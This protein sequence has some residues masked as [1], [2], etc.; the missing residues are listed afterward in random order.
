MN[1]LNIIQNYMF[2]V[3]ATIQGVSS[4]LFPGGG[5]LDPPNPI[6]RQWWLFN[7]EDN[8]THDPALLPR[9]PQMPSFVS[10]F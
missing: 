10:L 3:M 9:H 5:N 2:T 7:S 1:F 8:T 4:V 6:H